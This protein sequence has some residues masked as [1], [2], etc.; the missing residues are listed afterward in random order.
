MK[1][2]EVKELSTDELKARINE[3]TATLSRLKF[4]HAVSAIENPL[5][6]RA[7]RKVIA[8]LNTELKQ[9]ELNAALSA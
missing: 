7:A 3:E 8:R 5:K 4:S 9:R 1:Y 2:A 6:I